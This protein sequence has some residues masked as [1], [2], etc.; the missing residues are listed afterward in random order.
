MAANFTRTSLQYFYCPTTPITDIPVTI[1]CW[2][3]ANGLL[4]DQDL[5]R[6]G[7]AN[8]SNNFSN[9]LALQAQTAGILRWVY[10]GGNGSVM[11]L[12]S[13]NTYSAGVWN[14]AIGNTILINSHEV[15]LN[16][17]KTTSSSSA[18]PID[19][20]GLAAMAIGADPVAGAPNFMDGKIIEVAIWNATLT[21]LEKIS[22][23]KG[24][25][26]LRVRPASLVFYSPLVQ[27]TIELR[28]A[29]SMTNNNA[30]N[31]LPDYAAVYKQ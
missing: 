20:G 22:L 8:G 26:P 16:G 9:I 15:W 12:P 29:R 25:N 6:I 27:N 31:F 23:S 4:V 3:K 28:A 19:V 5:I 2:F 17:T 21:D 30:I 1:S 13:S 10:R 7:G 24:Y 14:H 11:F 18:S